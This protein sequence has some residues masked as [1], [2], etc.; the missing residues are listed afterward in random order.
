MF[1]GEPRRGQRGG[2]PWGV[3]GEWETGGHRR[4]GPGGPPPWLAELLGLERPAR[5]RGGRRRRGDV[6]AAILDVIREAEEPPNGY[7]VIQA[8]TERSEGA[9]KPS[10]G[11]VYPTI[12]QLEAEGLVV[13]EEVNG[14]R[15]HRLTQAGR[16]WCED[17]A[18]E[19][20]GVWRPF[21]SERADRA[22]DAVQHADIKAE[23]PRVMSAIWQIITTGSDR[24][25]A[26]AADVLVDARRRLY[27]ILADGPDPDGRD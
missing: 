10:P 7:Q 19:L 25:R 16:D 24:Q 4:G 26:A 17:N 1:G 11:S 21:A 13:T 5:P 23:I 15:A 27:G 18:D 14:R 3:W 6:R 20:S 8:I 9:W 22:A 12:Q 2:Q